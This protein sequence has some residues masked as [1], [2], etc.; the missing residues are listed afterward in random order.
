MG[1]RGQAIRL[2]MPVPESLARSHHLRHLR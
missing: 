2:M 1:R